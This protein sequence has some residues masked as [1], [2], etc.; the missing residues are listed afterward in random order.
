MTPSSAR[1]LDKLASLRFFA[2]FMVVIFHMGRIAA[3]YSNHLQ[4][5]YA[6]V[7]AYGYMGVS[8]FFVLSGFV[9]SHAN[10]N[11]KGWKKYLIG[12][13]TRVYPPHWIVTFSFGL[14]TVVM[15]FKSEGIHV[16][17]LLKFISNL[18]LVQAWFPAPAYHFSLNIVTWS[19]SV[20]IFFYMSFIFFRKLQDKYI[21]LL[22]ILSYLAILFWLITTHQAWNPKMHW[23]L[24]INPIARLPEFLTGMSVYRLYKLR[25][26]PRLW[27]PQ[28]NFIFI[29]AAMI[30]VAAVAGEFFNMGF[31]F[32]DPYTYTIIPI[33]F[34]FLMMIALLDEESNSYMRNKILV[35][36]GESSFAL[37]LIHRF[38]IRFVDF[39]FG[40]LIYVNGVV[41]IFFMLL[42]L[43]LSI[44]VSIG[45]YKFIE[46]PITK[47]LKNYFIEKFT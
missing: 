11:W 24:Y 38:I 1:Y 12:R 22:A 41:T 18:L 2:A 34:V 26:L 27:L 44:G 37:Y 29:L 39:A 5:A 30:A 43:V 40:N 21:F 47:Y 6:M 35:L 31:T 45:F 3:H 32:K 25:R 19:L 28:F 23:E 20:E 33:P 16:Y 9:I 7:Y 10:E 15:L 4:Y 13:I 14:I 36:L 17:S 42:I 8:I 46:L